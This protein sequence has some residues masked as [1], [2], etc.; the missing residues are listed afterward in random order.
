MPVSIC[1]RSGVISSATG[2]QIRDRAA[3]GRFIWLDVVGENPAEASRLLE[4]LGITGPDI[5][6]ALR[7]GQMGRLQIGQTKLRAVTWC[8]DF[9]GNLIEIHLVACGAG[10]ATLWSGAPEALND[11]R[12]KFVERASGLEADFHLAAGVLLQLLLGTL[13]QLLLRLDEQIAEMRVNLDRDAQVESSS[14]LPRLQK[15]QGISATFSRFSS[16]TRSAAVGIEAISGISPRATEEFNDYVEQVEDFE[17]QLFERR[18]WASDLTH[19]FSTRIAQMQSVHIER[20]TIFSIIFLPLTAITGFFGMNFE[21]MNQALAGY[22][23]FFLFGV[24]L[25]AASVMVTV[26]L[27]WRYGLIRLR[28]RR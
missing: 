5:A 17:E 18:R 6:W 20:L 1:E 11:I 16:A 10:V 24:I 23:A 7:F 12:F 13:D 2:E 14:V 4:T 21:W 27:L 22:P 8:A 3:R 25:P 15:L 28:G 26:L 19:D 9:S